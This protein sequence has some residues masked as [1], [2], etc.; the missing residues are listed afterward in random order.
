MST[1]KIEAFFLKFKYFLFVLKELSRESGE[2]D[3][4]THRASIHGITPQ[5]VPKWPA[6]SQADA[7]SLELHP[8]L[9]G[10]GHD[11]K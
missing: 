4:H 3:A 2:G 1:F 8:G 5:M 7:R 6:L 10:G 9:P 11:P